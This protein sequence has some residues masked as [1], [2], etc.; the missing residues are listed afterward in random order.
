MDFGILP[1]DPPVD[2]QNHV[3]GMTIRPKIVHV[4]ATS[5]AHARVL[6]PVLVQKDNNRLRGWR[7]Q[8]LLEEQV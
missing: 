7:S 2:A 6:V 5:R 3:A 1:L 4:H 8:T